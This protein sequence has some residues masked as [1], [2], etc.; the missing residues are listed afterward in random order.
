MFWPQGVRTSFP[1]AGH[2]HLLSN[3]AHSDAHEL[4]VRFCIQQRM[5]ALIRM[6]R[7]FV[8]TEQEPPQA[9]PKRR[10][11]LPVRQRFEQEKLAELVLRSALP[12]LPPRV[13]G[14]LKRTWRKSLNEEEAEP[15]AGLLKSE[16]SF[17]CALGLS[18][19]S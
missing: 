14:E 1:P 3:G 16:E 17:G 6:L 11:L 18:I 7:C 8:Q 10:A 19:Q 5:H 12:S 9:R 4:R 13:P 15:A 2:R